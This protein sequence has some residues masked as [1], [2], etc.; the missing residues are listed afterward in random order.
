MDQEQFPMLMEASKSNQE[1]LRTSRNFKGPLN[2][3][4]LATKRS[5]NN[6][7]QF[8]RAEETIENYVLFNQMGK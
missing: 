1:Q 8:I 6:Q 4:D 5:L 3:T 7:D 2:K